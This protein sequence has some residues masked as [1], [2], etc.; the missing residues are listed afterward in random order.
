MPFVSTRELAATLGF[1]DTSP[2]VRQACDEFGNAR[3]SGGDRFHVEVRGVAPD[4][5]STA[6]R[7]DGSYKVR[8]GFY[9]NVHSTR[10]S[11]PSLRVLTV[12]ARDVMFVADRGDGSYK[13]CGLSGA[14]CTVHTQQQRCG[15]EGGNC[16]LSGKPLLQMAS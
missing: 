12:P 8:A 5:V 3:Q 4:A 6:D 7:G 13:D 11:R 15:S 2:C 16:W 1:D 9:F 14:S 10:E